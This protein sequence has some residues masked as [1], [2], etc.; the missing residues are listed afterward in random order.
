LTDPDDDDDAGNRRSIG[1]N[2][3]III[4]L[5]L[6]I[7]LYLVQHLMKIDHA[8]QSPG[9]PGFAIPLLQHALNPN[10]PSFLP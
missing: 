9:P 1:L 6:V 10:T 8:T 2:G 4:L 7:G 3:L 5:V